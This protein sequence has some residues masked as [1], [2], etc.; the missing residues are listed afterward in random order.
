VASL[1]F[2]DL[3]IGSE[4]LIRAW[5]LAGFSILTPQTVDTK[6]RIGPYGADLGVMT[7][8]YQPSPAS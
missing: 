4:D 3:S 5:W 2:E 8:S 7:R 6:M 1:N